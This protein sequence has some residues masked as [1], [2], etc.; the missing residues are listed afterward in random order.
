M[1]IEC[2][3]ENMK[4]RGMENEGVVKIKQTVQIKKGN[5]S[6]NQLISRLSSSRNIL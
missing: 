4:N 1:K 5:L 3:R 2:E 6:G